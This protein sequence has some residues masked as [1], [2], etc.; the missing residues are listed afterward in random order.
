VCMVRNKDESTSCVS[1]S[2]PRP[3]AQQKSGAGEQNLSL[4]TPGPSV[5]Q[6]S[7]GLK[8]SSGGGTSLGTEGSLKLGAGGGLQFGSG[9]LKLG[10]HG[11]KFGSAQTAPSSGSSALLFSAAAA[12]TIETAGSSLVKTISTDNMTT[13]STS[14]QF[15]PAIGAYQKSG[16]EGTSLSSQTSK[17]AAISSSSLSGQQPSSGLMLGTGGGISL[18][19]EGGLKLG[20]IAQGTPKFGTG[21]GISLGTEGGLKLGSGGGLQLGSG[22]LKLGGQGGFKFESPQA[23]PFSFSASTSSASQFSSSAS[24]FPSFTKPQ[25]VEGTSHPFVFGAKLSSSQ[26]S[27]TSLGSGIS[28]VPASGGLLVPGL[29]PNAT[30]Q[31]PVFSLKG[32]SGQIGSGPP[33]MNFLPSG[34]NPLSSSSTLSSGQQVQQGFNF[35]PPASNTMMPQPTLQFGS[36]S[37]G[38]VKLGGKSLSSSP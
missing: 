30:S 32:S 13:S 14:L 26:S 8:L 9:G 35:T 34:G 22:S 12:T 15:T 5:K 37:A 19:T 4:I 33:N 24:Q 23:A 21:G 17:F 38:G 7:G 2:S 28:S 3:G 11:L 20:G 36:G 31:N 16:T 29:Q 1:C 18:G 10:G 25:S 6:S 27:Q